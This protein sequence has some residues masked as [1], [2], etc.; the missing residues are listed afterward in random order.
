MFFKPIG[1][2]IIKLNS[3]SSTNN[4]AADLLKQT[5]VPNGTIILTERQESGK[6][7][8]GNHWESEPG[9]NLTFSVVLYSEVDVSK[10]FQLSMMAALSVF[11]M[12][13]SMDFYQVKMKWPN[14]IYVG[15]KKVGGI[16]IENN[17]QKNKIKHSIIGIGL[18][19]NQRHFQHP[20]AASLAQF[21]GRDWSLEDI[22]SSLC[23]QMN[24]Y[25]M[26][27]QKGDSLMD[28]YQI[29][30][31]GWRENRV[32]EI[33]GE[34]VK[35]MIQEYTTEGLMVLKTKQGLKKYDLKEIEFK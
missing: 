30:T 3:V 13:E 32:F 10:S 14:D 23:S 6:G 27:V 24:R 34:L 4:Y 35:G 29:N 31:L 28:E 1:S 15:E 2:N 7:Q 11:R 19:V 8:R 22:L 21:S 26:Q 25:Y 9:K 12:L 16:L 18:N 17:I 20:K 5:N 33:Q